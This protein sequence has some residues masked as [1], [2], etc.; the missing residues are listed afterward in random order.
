M[1]NR[2]FRQIINLLDLR[3][4]RRVPV[5][6]QT[7][8]AECGLACLA[9]IC[10][11]FGKNIDLIY[12]RRKFNLSAR[13]ATLAGINGIAEQLGMATRALSLEL[14]ELRVLKTP[15]I[16]HW[17][18]SHFVV[19]VS[20]KRNRY[21]LHD[22]ARGIRYISRE[23]MSRYFTGVALEVWPGSEFQSETLQT[24][25]SLRSL[26]NSIYGIKRT[27]AK[28]FC[29]SVVIEAINLLMPVGTQLVMDHAIPAGDRG[30]LTLISAALMF[31]ILLKAATSTLRAWSSLVMSTLI[32]VQW[33]SGL[34][35]HLLRLP[36]AFFERR[37]LGDIQSRFDSLDTLRA[38]FTTSVIGFIMD[39]I[40][41]VG[42][43]V[44]ML[45]YGGYLT[46]IVL[47]FTTIYI[48]IRLVTYG[49]YRQISEECLVREARAASY[50]MET[51]YGIATV[52]IQGM[53]GIRG[54]HW[55]NMKIDAINSG[56]KLTRM[57][58]LFGGINTFVTACDQIVILWLGAGLV[59][60]NQMTIGMFVAFSSFRGQFSERVASLTS[61]LLQL[62]I[63]S[64][65]NERIADI[66][67]HEK[68]EKKPEIE[69]VADMGPISL[70]TNG[71]SY[72]YDS[73][74]APIFSALSLSVAPGESVAITGASGAGKTTLMKVLCGLFE[75]DSGRVLI[76]GIDIRQ[77][78]INNYHRMIA[79][80]MQDDRLFSGSIREN[81][82]GFAE[83]MD[84]EWMVE[85]ARASHIHD[86]I[87]NMPMGYETLI[88]ELG[89]GL[90]GGQKQRI[91]IAR[92]LYRKPGILFM[93]EATSALDSES[94]HFVNVAIKN[95]NITRV[96][97]AHRETTLR[98][99]DR[100][101]SI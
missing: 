50:F 1:T 3:W 78:G 95:M 64:L 7:E 49:N 98:T 55:L 60:D 48:F 77:I 70:E 75:P 51:L 12:L 16:L 61:F 47:C 63:M 73:Q 6:H 71:L 68:E 76:N 86:V 69:I 66:A 65:H 19:L 53:V 33:Q 2:N 38:T 24:R 10:G 26:I 99:V 44:M 96:I 72:R 54:A 13:G 57:D 42:V 85:C 40:M 27:L 46:W 32:N 9:M 67:L 92:A 52:K 25:I 41:V 14:D 83:E 58:L 100:V 81:I 89:E 18:F 30:L 80:V 21:V 84:E 34:F 94:E 17:D 62:R 29:L 45:L 36:L 87:M 5:I 59:I 88:G 8:T 101:I 11:H 82:C 91:F 79:C 20:V 23:E 90:S 37:K 15:C 31:F 39:S 28:I 74:S 97:I 43:C 56:I 22:P 93:D 35:D 4:Q